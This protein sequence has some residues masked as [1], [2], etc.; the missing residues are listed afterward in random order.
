MSPQD[1]SRVMGISPG[2]LAGYVTDIRQEC[3]SA[4]GLEPET[5]ISYD[6]LRQMFAPVIEHLPKKHS[7]RNEK[8]E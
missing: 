7:N 2:T 1:A 6:W 5:A 4:W 8:S 3:R